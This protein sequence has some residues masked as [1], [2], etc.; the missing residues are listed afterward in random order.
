MTMTIE[1]TRPDIKALIQ[2]HLRA[3]G[4]SDPQEVIFKALRAT[5]EPRLTGADLIA[6]IQSSP[7]RE[8][9]LEVPSEV[10]PVRDVDL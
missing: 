1:I 8:V 10:S 7:Y 6:A 2:K 5:E 9:S 4:V 3:S